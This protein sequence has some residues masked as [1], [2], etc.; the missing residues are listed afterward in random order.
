MRATYVE[1]DAARGRDATFRWLTEEV[2]E[3]ARALRTGDRDN[4]I[5]EFGDVL[6]WLASLA[7][8]EGVD[9]DEA[10]ARYAH[11]CPRVRE[12]PLRMRAP[13]TADIRTPAEDDRDAGHRRAP[14]VAQLLPIVGGGARVDHCRSRTIDAR[15]RATGS[16]RRRPGS[17]SA[18]GSAG[19]ICR[20]RASTP[21]RRCP[22]IAGRGWRVPPCSRSCATPAKE[23][24]AGQRAVSGRPASL[25]LDRLRAGWNLQRS[26]ASRWTRSRP[27]W[28]RISRRRRARPRS[29]PRGAASLLPSDGRGTATAPFEPTDDDWWTRRIL[30]PFG[31]AISR[32]VVVRGDDGAIEGF[33][34]F[35]YADAEGGHLEIDFG[36]EC[37]A[38][39]ADHGTRARARCS[40]TSAS[41]RGVGLWVAMVRPAGGPH[42][43]A[44]ARA[45]DHDAVPVPLDVPAARRAERARARA[46]TRPIDADVVVAVDDPAFP[47]NAGP[48]RLIVRGGEAVVRAAPRSRIRRDAD[49][50]PVGA[51]Q[52]VPPPCRTRS[53]WATCAATTPPSPGCTAA[54][55]P[56]PWCPFF[57]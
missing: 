55:R 35:R 53:V 54:G 18:S 40:P 5:H 16:W 29:R 14:G 7:N 56:D 8:L 57:F 43:V 30:R 10:A 27:T 37:L 25:S 1:R 17:G 31:D 52:R 49:R 42:R 23:G 28:A 50:H 34:A 48:W 6:A 36:L 20:C 46:D 13:M 39:A 19:A 3:L 32:A 41:F 33:A 4:L 47:E 2:G 21:W 51:V 45:A 38:F 15:T 11:G 24:T 22:S 44:G 12:A 9:L 26:I